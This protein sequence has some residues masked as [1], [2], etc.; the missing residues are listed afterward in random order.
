[1]KVNL[2]FWDVDDW[3]R[4]FPISLLRP[5]FEL[6]AGALTF[7]ERAK[8]TFPDSKVFAVCRRELL[9]IAAEMGYSVDLAGVDPKL[10]TIALCG[11]TF[12]TQRAFRYIASSKTPTVFISQDVPVAVFAP[13]GERRWAEFLSAPPREEDL[14]KL[15]AVYDAVEL[16]VKTFRTLWDIISRNGEL[17]EEDFDAFYRRRVVPYAGE[18][19]V[20]LYNPDEVFIGS[21][22]TVD[23]YAVLDAREGPVIIERG[24]HIASGSIVVGPAVVG[25]ESRVMPFARIREETTV[26]PVCR[27]GGE[28]EASIFLGFSNKYHDGFLGHSYVGEWVN[29]GALTTNS[30][31]KNNYSPVRVSMPWGEIETGLVKVGAFIGDHAK[32]GIGTLVPT[33]AVVGTAVNFYGGG[34]MPKYVPPFVWGSWRDGFT[35]YKLEKALQTADVVM[36]RRE[37]RLTE[38]TKRLLIRIHGFFGDDR[39]AFISKHRA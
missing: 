22:A 36:R 2:V 20:A 14:A 13:P 19:R 10:P 9:E 30:D 15:A 12:F 11:T 1:M 4:F 26:G 17:V 7:A 35:H 29:L 31:L 16:D 37:R 39:T 38:A 8:L 18:Q 24:A 28:V 32:L 3:R 33:G 23:A 6:R 27:V 5:A 25:A 34:M 21:G